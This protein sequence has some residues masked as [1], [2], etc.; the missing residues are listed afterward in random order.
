MTTSTIEII[1]RAE[2]DIKM[3]LPPGKVQEICFVIA[4]AFMKQTFS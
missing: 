3:L 2:T 1:P 4:D